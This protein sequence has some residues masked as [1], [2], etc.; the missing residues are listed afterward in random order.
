[1]F[2]GW[3]Q[4]W[5]TFTRVGWLICPDGRVSS[6]NKSNPTKQHSLRFC[7]VIYI[8][9]HHYRYCLQL[10]F[11][12]HWAHLYASISDDMT[13][14]NL[15]LHKTDKTVFFQPRLQTHQ[16]VVMFKLH[17]PCQLWLQYYTI[18]TSLMLMYLAA[19]HRLGKNWD[20]LCWGEGYCY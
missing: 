16:F 19:H 11:M 3:K 1:M 17:V 15:I 8:D 6:L 9:Q 12:K 20:S 18:W 2:V 4:L 13:S 10:R 14:V 7:Q 5:D